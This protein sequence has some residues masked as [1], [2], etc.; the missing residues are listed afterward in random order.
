MGVLD[1]EDMVKE[2]RV[3]VGVE[4]LAGGA[5]QPAGE[6]PN[7]RSLHLGAVL[8]RH[9]VAWR[10]STVP[11]SRFNSHV[12]EIVL[13]AAERSGPEYKRRPVFK[14]T[15]GVRTVATRPPSG[16]RRA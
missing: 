11:C 12:P 7:W 3:E 16:I 10:V 14:G 6:Q 13:R 8:A 2:E 4:L 15:D 1:V 9:W 5:S